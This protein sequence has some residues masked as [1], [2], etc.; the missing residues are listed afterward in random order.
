MYYLGKYNPETGLFNKNIEENNWNRLRES[1]E[2]VE[3]YSS[4][5]YF[6]L[7][8]AFCKN[9]KTGE[10]VAESYEVLIPTNISEKYQSLEVV[11]NSNKL[12]V[13]PAFLEYFN[14][15]VYNTTIY[16]TQNNKLVH[17]SKYNEK[18]TDYLEICAVDLETLIQLSSSSSS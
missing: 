8:K 15:Q 7:D 18:G 1:L 2:P 12:L 5:K 17:F 13:F 11:I 4:L 6:G 16:K 3:E 9:L 14:K 10:I